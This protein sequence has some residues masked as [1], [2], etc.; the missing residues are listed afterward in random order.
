MSPEARRPSDE[1]PPDNALSKKQL[2][3]F[4]SS[5][6]EDDAPPAAPGGTRK[7]PQLELPPAIVQT[8]KLPAIEIP[9]AT[10]GEIMPPPGLRGSPLGPP[11][12]ASGPPAP[13]PGLPA[14]A[15]G[16][17][18]APPTAPAPG[19]SSSASS[20]KEGA[21]ARKARNVSPAD[22]TALLPPEQ[23]PLRA[24]GSPAASGRRGET[25]ERRGDAPEKTA[26][27][28]ARAK[29]K[30]APPP[31]GIPDT[32]A[33]PPEKNPMRRDAPKPGEPDRHG[34]WRLPVQETAPAG[35]GEHSTWDLPLSEAMGQ[36]V[37]LPPGGAHRDTT[38]SLDKPGRDRETVEVKPGSETARRGDSRRAREP[39]WPRFQKG[40]GGEKGAPH[41]ELRPGTSVG[42]MWIEGVL[43]RGDGFT[44]YA[45][46]DPDSQTV[47]VEVASASRELDAEA[48][49]AAAQ[50]VS[51]VEDARLAKLVDA[52]VDKGLAFAVYDGGRG[53]TAESQLA[54]LR[55]KAERSARIARDAALALSV[56]HSAGF[57][58]GSLTAIDLLVDDAGRT[59]VIGLGRP[60][61]RSRQGEELAPLAAAATFT[62]PEL[63]RGAAPTAASD[64]HALGAILYALV[65]LVPPGKHPPFLR[66]A[67][68]ACPPALEAIV[69]RAMN[70]RPAG[71]YPSLAA[72]AADLER[73]L[74]GIA[75]EAPPVKKSARILRRLAARRAVLAAGAGALA[76]ALVLVPLLAGPSGRIVRARGLAREAESLVAS[77][78]NGAAAKWREAS[79]LAPRDVEVVRTAPLVASA[80]AASAVRERDRERAAS[81]R[82][83][84]EHA[85]EAL[86][87]A[88][89]RRRAAE[90]ALADRRAL[91][92]RP[93]TRPSGTLWAKAELRRVG[94]DAEAAAAEGEALGALL[95]ANAL[96]PGGDAQ[97]LLAEREKE[98]LAAAERASDPASIAFEEAASSVAP[99]PPSRV[100]IRTNPAGASVLLERYKER[101]GRLVARPFDPDRPDDQPESAAALPERTPLTHL[102]L[103]PGSYLARV[104][105]D[106]FKTA[107]V[108]IFIPPGMKRDWEVTLDLLE[109]TDDN[110]GWVLVPGGP[111]WFRSRGAWVDVPAFLMR[112]TEVALPSGRP[113]GDC[114]LVDARATAAAAD[115]R[116]P[117]AEELEKAFRGVDG[118]RFPWG[119]GFDLAYVKPGSATEPAL[120]GS[121]EADVS[122]YGIKDLA[123]SLSEIV[124]SPELT[125]VLAG[126]SFHGLDPRDFELGFVK[127]NV[128][129]DRKIERAGIRLVRSW[130]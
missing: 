67:T 120:A 90:D 1:K 116:L 130:H 22:P 118:R 38:A 109:D 122:P 60:F 77:D 28:P 21:T 34:T 125:T 79:A 115:A 75:S 16:P 108:P 15:P 53:R 101:G 25:S 39:G 78:P 10:S 127:L 26:E 51:R 58:H 124:S 59:R 96:A 45:A 123:S 62:A 126:G 43:A 100:T 106:R 99:P 129:D 31:R 103:P 72:F 24:K 4:L 19:P 54:R 105:L 11:A 42:R 88:A 20:R 73:F 37:G 93:G 44:R 6:D 13:A 32:S 41:G 14:P 40:S 35:P 113:R 50:K 48:F 23:N 114:S 68:L 117:T 47:L 7:L 86:H 87:R 91:D 107:N 76:T 65:A 55:P 3:E 12:P 82:S 74:A 57:H 30:E 121:S 69:A 5:D 119:N 111:A 80:L 95:L 98:Y 56:A 27:T 97:H 84:V 49:L 33:L 9:L 85:E 66:D 64:Q 110:A 83:L 94:A 17:A 92:D 63:G 112:E 29:K 71:R 89:E 102:E 46:T 70:A 18:A 8:L 52:G 128:P 36:T 2:D 61:A 104:R 81:A